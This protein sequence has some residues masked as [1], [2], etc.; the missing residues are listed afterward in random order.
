MY[1]TLSKQ[2]Y[3]NWTL[4]VF[5]KKKANINISDKRLTTLVS[6]G[7]EIRNIEV[8]VTQICSQKGYAILLH[9]GDSF[10]NSISLQLIA[11][12][13]EPKWLL[14]GAINL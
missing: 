7:N 10:K 3:S 14:G 9:E 4:T 5:L 1:N 6:E 2:S 8:A 12:A 11:E 13:F